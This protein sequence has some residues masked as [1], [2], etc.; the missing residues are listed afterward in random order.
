MKISVKVRNIVYTM[1]PNLK[2][3]NNY[4]KEMITVL[5]KIEKP[6]IWTTPSGMKI[7]QK[8]VSVTKRKVGNEIIT[9]I[10]P[11]TISMLTNK[12][13]TTK[14]K[15]AFMPNLVHSL[16]ASHIILLIEKIINVYKNHHNVEWIYPLYTIHDC[17]GSP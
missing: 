7:T 9:K 13:N 3:L 6:V 15:T 1:H 4:F 2:S 16:D 12:I 14:Q 11:I 8:Y 17:F 10:K 5:N